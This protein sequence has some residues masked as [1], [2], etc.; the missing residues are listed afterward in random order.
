MEFLTKCG[1]TI[2]IDGPQID[3]WTVLLICQM[4]QRGVPVPNF[5]DSKNGAMEEDP[6]TI[7]QSTVCTG[8]PSFSSEI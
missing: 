6:W 1:T 4:I 5:E 7:D 3:L 8:A 2:A